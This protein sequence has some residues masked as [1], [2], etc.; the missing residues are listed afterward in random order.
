VVRDILG[1]Q[2][3]AE[4]LRVELRDLL[5]ERAAPSFFASNC[6]TCL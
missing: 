4:L 6:E 2:R 1:E 3:R 5:I